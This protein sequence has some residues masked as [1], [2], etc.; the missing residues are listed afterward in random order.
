MVIIIVFLF[1][2][3][4]RGPCRKW[5]YSGHVKHVDD[6]DD[7]DG[8]GGDYDDDEGYAIIR[9][10]VSQKRYKTETKLPW[11]TNRNLQTPYSTV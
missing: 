10:R 1:S 11:N 3:I 2:G 7:D 6:D 9:R 5:H 4:S 8:G